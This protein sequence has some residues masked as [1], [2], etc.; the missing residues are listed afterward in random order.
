MAHLLR[1]RR[2]LEHE[3]GDLLACLEAYDR[4]EQRAFDT[5]MGLVFRS[6]E[7]ATT[8][9]ADRGC[10]MLIASDKQLPRRRKI[11]TRFEL[12]TLLSGQHMEFS[13]PAL[14]R[15]WHPIEEDTGRGL[16]RWAEPTAHILF[17]AGSDITSLRLDVAPVR[18]CLPVQF[19]SFHQHETAP[20][21]I[22]LLERDDPQTVVVPLD[23]RRGDTVLIK[24]MVDRFAAAQRDGPAAPGTRPADRGGGLPDPLPPDERLRDAVAARQGPRGHRDAMGGGATAGQ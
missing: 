9:S 5:A 21:S 6:L 8:P 16:F 4:R 20:S 22:T 1:E 18:D 12:P 14:H 13:S 17:R 15:G 3:Y 10:I 23:K 11:R 19:L 24:L 2:H 7:D